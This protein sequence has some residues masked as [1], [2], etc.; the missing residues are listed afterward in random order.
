MHRRASI[1]VEG[2]VERRFLL[3][4]VGVVSAVLL[5]STPALAASSGQPLWMRTY[6]PAAAS[7]AFRDV[8]A[9]AN[10]YVYAAGLKRGDRTT[11]LVLAKYDG[12]GSRTWL[13]S[14]RGDYLATD[15]RRVV[16][17]ASGYVYVCGRVVWRNGEDGIL[18][19]KYA[20]DGTRRW[21]RTWN[22]RHGTG[23]SFQDAPCSMA[24]DRAGSVYLAAHSDGS[25]GVSGLVLAKYDARGKRLWAVRYLDPIDPAGLGTVP[26]DLALDGEGGVYVAGRGSYL[27]KCDGDRYTALTLKFSGADGSL[28]ARAAYGAPYNALAASLD[29]RGSTVAV[30]GTVQDQPF[31]ESSV[32]KALV[33]NYDLSLGQRYAVAYK[34]P[35]EGDTAAAND[36]AVDPAGNVLATGWSSTLAVSG[37]VEG[38]PTTLSLGPDGALRWRQTH[39]SAFGRGSGLLVDDA[40]NSYVWG[41]VSDGGQLSLIKYDG[42]GDP[43]WTQTWADEAGYVSRGALAFGT[44]GLYMCGQIRAHGRAV[45][46]KYAL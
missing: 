9:G 19:V 29:V 41:W 39:Q 37:Q 6:R 34:G 24:L 27:R 11:T 42:R 10:G 30:C 40:G 31:S 5:L 15:G 14:F 21:S 46:V 25:K 1:L 28:L 16:L 18:L 38:G 43:V 13:R 33:I 8:A 35:G 17:D 20:P 32:T 36:V 26:S 4:C 22:P 7:A 3:G 23:W 45:L 2:H 12:A 44:D